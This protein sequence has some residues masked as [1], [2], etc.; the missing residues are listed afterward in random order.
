MILHI[1]YLKYIILHYNGNGS[2]SGVAK[3]DMHVLY[4]A[5]M[6]NMHI[7]GLIQQS[8]MKKSHPGS[9]KKYDGSALFSEKYIH[10]FYNLFFHWISS[11]FQ[12]NYI[13]TRGKERRMTI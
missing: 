4:N 12:K 3:R 13:M 8:S 11:L 9:Y 1:F 5:Q 2:E 7:T 6:D 10:V